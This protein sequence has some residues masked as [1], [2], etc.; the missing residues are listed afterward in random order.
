ML[1]RDGMDRKSGDRIHNAKTASRRLSPAC[2]AIAENRARRQAAR[3]LLPNAFMPAMAAIIFLGL[4]NDR[5]R[6]FLIGY[7]R[8]LLS[9]KSS[10]RN[11]TIRQPAPVFGETSC[12]SSLGEVSC[13]LPAHGLAARQP[14]SA[15]EL[16]RV[17]Q[18]IAFLI[19]NGG[20]IDNNAVK[21]K[22]QSLDRHAL[23]LAVYLRDIEAKNA[24]E[25]VEQE[26]RS[27]DSGR[28]HYSKMSLS[29]RTRN[30]LALM[31]I[32]SHRGDGLMAGTVPSG[33]SGTSLGGD[34]E[35][36]DDG[37]QSPSNRP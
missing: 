24:W 30:I 32:W 18:I 11:Q 5:L 21:Q 20:R 37:P 36:H 27:L 2:L 6:Q 3:Q 1:R 14:N 17:A 7:G 9:G 8:S 22:W 26:M 10:R 23:P 34:L 28:G 19:R 16:E 35:A 15:L 12:S 13:A 33:P 29:I 4:M 25:E 31:P